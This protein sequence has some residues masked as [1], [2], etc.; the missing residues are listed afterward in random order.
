LALDPLEEA[1]FAFLSGA[2]CLS[3][4]VFL[5]CAIGRA[6]PAVFLAGGAAAVAC[7]VR[8]QARAGKRL[9]ALSAAWIAILF[10]VLTPFFLAYFFNALAPE[11]SPDGSGYHLG[12]V[13]RYLEHG[14]FTWDFATDIN[15]RFHSFYT[16]FPQG[17]EMLFLVAFAFGRHSSAALVHLAFLLA[18]TLLLICYGRR[19]QM[20]RAGAFAAAI[21]FVSPIFG[22]TGNSAYNDVALVTAVFAVF[23][24]LQ[25]ND[26]RKEE[27]LLILIGLLS[28]LCAAI[29]YTGG[30]AT[31]F[32]VAWLV[33]ARHRVSLMKLLIPMVLTVAP[34]LLR[35]WLQTGDPFA[36]FLNHWFPDRFY[37]VAMERDYLADVGHFESL[38]HWWEL[39]LDVTLYGAKIP[40]FLGPVFLLAPLGLLA[41]RTSHGG[42]LVAAAAFFGL[43]FAFNAATRFLMPGIP[44]L[45][46]A[47]GLAIENSI[48]ILPML[49]I[50][51]A[52]L[53]WPTLIP[54][55]AA[56][57][58]WRLREIP[59]RAALRMEPEGDFIARRLPDCKLQAAIEATIPKSKKIFSFAGRCQ[60]Y[61]DRTI[62]VGYESAEGF[63][64]QRT[65]CAARSPEDRRGVLEAFQ[66]SGIAALWIDDTDPIATDMRQNINSWGLILL[67]E[68]AGT[69]L[70]GLE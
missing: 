55:Y 57:W 19:F 64:L 40:G 41:L 30:P 25:V 66:R 44:F 31:L 17:L 16:D 50:F 70:Y 32:A 4:L 60:A 5:L 52:L 39:P 3:T 46:L 21:V 51:Q 22:L 65:L 36:P 43:P 11:V 47:L 63:A 24:L 27:N 59:V 54:L 12:N 38:G 6:R 13:A 14:G 37:S 15:S 67:V 61:V 68:G 35:N 53:C 9:P 56:D 20:P 10:C 1:L 49:A 58:S 23:Y 28:G 34:W 29:K 69:R 62:V 42:K 2:A 18:L 33:L 45:A 48:G 26:Q 8:G 7:A